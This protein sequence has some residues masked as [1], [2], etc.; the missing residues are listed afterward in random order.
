MN[1]SLKAVFAIGCLAAAT[2][3]LALGAVR[4]ST[5]TATGGVRGGANG[6]PACPPGWLD[7]K[8]PVLGLQAHVPTN[9]WV[10]LRAG[11]M[12]TVENQANPAALAFLVPFRP[13]PGATATDVAD[14]FGRYVTQ[15]QPQFKAE[16]VHGATADRA[17]TRFTSQVSGQAIEGRYCSLLGA[18][19]SMAFVIG[20]MAPQGEL[21]RELPTLQAI[22]RGFGFEPPKG[23]WVEY[24]S[25]A[26]GFTLT[27]PKGWEVQS[28]D[29]QSGKDDIDWAARDLRKPFSR[30]FQACPRYCSPALLQDPLH[31]IRGY[32]AAQFQGHQQ[33]VTTALGELS[34]NI[35]LLKWSV[36]RDLTELFR[37]LN[38]QLAQM[39]SAL[40]VG[41]TDITVYDCL[42][43]VD[44]EGRSV[45]VAF[46]A[47]IQTLAIRG[48]FSGQLLDWRVT[49]RGWCALPED[50]VVDSPVLEKVCASMQLTPAFLNRILQGNA[51]ASAKIRETYAY[52]NEVDNQIRQS[53]WDTMDAI[54]EMNYDALRDYG[55]YVNERTGRIEQIDPDKV[56]KNSH[57]QYVSREEVQRGVSPDSATVLREAYSADY[58]RGVYGR[59]EF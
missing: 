40:Q 21:E 12:L 2:I 54:A 9:Y 53:R 3:P 34:Q 20:F 30:A 24:S 5:P 23:R 16:H 51:Q 25:P 6:R 13:R 28:G 4:D 37:G 59:I 42:A 18:G 46:V 41:Q 57:G 36:N 29:G 35:Q 39:L 58:M 22:A 45:L 26:G 48:S 43:R 56:V 7:F 17:T 11:T 44:L 38:Q 31:V 15:S 10:R 14:R 33:M 27:L 55:G 1:S 47:G 19:G 50:F 32:R 52:M 8:N 49:L